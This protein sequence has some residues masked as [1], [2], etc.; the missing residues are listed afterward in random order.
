MSLLLT[1][2]GD[3]HSTEGNGSNNEQ[4]G[5][6]PAASQTST[7]TVNVD[8]SASPSLSTISVVVVQ[9][10]MEFTQSK[11]KPS[12]IARIG[13]D[14]FDP[15]MIKLLNNHDTTADCVKSVACGLL[16]LEQIR[17]KVG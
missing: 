15:I 3:R 6:T 9:H 13:E 8:P 14:I 17:A 5:M 11:S 12:S 16:V 7:T 1:T 4:N 2:A 10:L